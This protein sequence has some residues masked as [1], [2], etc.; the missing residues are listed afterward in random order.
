MAYKEHKVEKV[1]WT[2]EE[3]SMMLLIDTPTLR[4]WMSGFGIKPRRNRQ[5]ERKLTSE[6]IQTLRKIQL[7]KTEGYTLVGVKLNWDKY[8][9]D[10]NKNLRRVEL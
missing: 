3:V 5:N 6:N 4:F 10:E 8:D 1:Y 9:F 7:M 2:M